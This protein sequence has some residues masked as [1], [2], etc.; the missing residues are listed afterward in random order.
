M[1]YIITKSL[2]RYFYS[3]LNI[4]ILLRNGFSRTL[5][6]LDLKD[7]KGS[8]TLFILGSG[9]SI[10]SIGADGWNTIKSS[11]SIGLNF[12]PIHD[13]VPD[14][15]MF[16]MPRGDR[17]K[18]FYKLLVQK[19]DTYSQI[20]LIFKGLY[21]NRKDFGDILNV[22]KLFPK[23]LLNNIY[24]GK[25]ISIPGRSENEFASALK[26]LK[27]IGFFSK[28]RSID[29]IAQYRGT[30]TCAIIL[31][32]KAGYKHIVLC[33]VDLNNTKYFYEDNATYYSEKGID[34][35]VSGQEGTI[36]KTNVTLPEVLPISSAIK[37]LDTFFNNEFGGKIYTSNKESALSP[38]L[39]YYDLSQ[40]NE[41]L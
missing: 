12:W 7:V 40:K 21:K 16:E 6:D 10:N 30:V 29:C 15:L 36:H 39:D 13:F 22:S 28:S 38:M 3:I 19:E 32:I 8:E 23:K 14:L 34:V 25:E 24:L 33:G 9:S 11:T 20:P 2:Y 31:G 27:R 4:R 1:L 35:P 17:G 18:Q 26:N 41:D 37:I 5:N